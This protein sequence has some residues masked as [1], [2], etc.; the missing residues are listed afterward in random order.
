MGIPPVRQTPARLGPC[1]V[2][3]IAAVRPV[4]R[5]RQGG[6]RRISG[7]VEVEGGADRPINYYRFRQVCGAGCP[8]QSLRLRRLGSS[9][10]TYWS[11]PGTGRRSPS[12]PA[13]TGIPPTTTSSWCGDWRCR[14][15][16]RR[17]GALGMGLSRPDLRPTAGH[18]RGHLRASGTRSP[19]S[20]L[21]KGTHDRFNFHTASGANTA[22][23]PTVHASDGQRYVES[24]CPSNCCAA[25]PPVRIRTVLHM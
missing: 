2:V 5:M 15:P 6:I 11:S 12:S 4:P 18:G 8:Y 20:P 19:S 1:G 17:L 3:I 13:P 7:A 25:G 24:G 21:D 16:A 9:I 23:R 10:R 22:M 14:T